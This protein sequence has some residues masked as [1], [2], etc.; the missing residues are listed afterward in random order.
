[1]LV[2]QT[3]GMPFS[4][5]SFIWSQI[6]IGSIWSTNLKL[7]VGTPSGP[8]ALLF[9]IFF[10]CFATSTSSNGYMTVCCSSSLW[11][12]C[13]MFPSLSFSM[14]N[15]CLKWPNHR[16]IIILVSVIMCFLSSVIYTLSSWSSVLLYLV[17]VSWY[18][19]KIDSASNTIFS[20]TLIPRFRYSLY[21][22]RHFCMEARRQ[23]PAKHA[24]HIVPYW[25]S[26]C[27]FHCRRSNFAID[28]TGHYLQ[29]G[30][31]VDGDVCWLF[32][33]DHQHQ[34]DVCSTPPLYVTHPFHL[35]GLLCREGRQCRICR[36]R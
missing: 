20:P 27:Q 12:T 24:Q 4:N 13:V 29:L 16:P 25:H 36:P 10:I 33:A 17:F 2:L 21:W 15:R 7:S 23:P 8:H 30:P 28:S 3:V 5:S 9:C 26:I 14:F 19:R 35:V 18:G 32:G 6:S 1:M 34:D 22:T 31:P 11:V